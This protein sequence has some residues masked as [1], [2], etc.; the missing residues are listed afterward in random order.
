MRNSGIQN[1]GPG[2][3]NIDN[4]AV[5]DDATVYVGQSPGREENTEGEAV[6]RRADVGVITVLDE[7]MRALVAALRG[8]GNVRVEVHDDGSRCHEADIDASGRRVRIAATQAAGPGQ[9][10]AVLAFQRLQRDYA[11]AIVA[12]VGI[13][14]GVRPSLRLGDVVVAT[15]VIYYD[16]RKETAA[17]TLRRGETRPVPIRVKHAINHFFS[18][19]GNPYRASFDDP[20][21]VTRPGNVLPGPIASGEAVVADARSEIRRYVQRFNDKT[22]AVETEAGGVAE[23]FH[24]MAEGS[25][26]KGWLSI[27]GISD[28]ADARKGDAYH[29]I[30]S[31]HA[32][33]ILLEM[34]PYLTAGR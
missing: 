10:R 12:L 7:E 20:D 27:R 16:L 6:G 22:M 25:G 1:F 29:D 11:P 4:S 18:S 33:E 13:A 14:G 26:I 28:L 30:A 19:N 31:W 8:A 2:T 24:E 34:L 9:R 23:A 3:I 15:E 17:G 5:G 32:A 21:G